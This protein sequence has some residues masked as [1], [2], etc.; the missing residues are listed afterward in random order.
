MLFFT[1]HKTLLDLGVTSMVPSH[2]RDMT[3]IILSLSQLWQYFKHNILFKRILTFLF[4]FQLMNFL[5][6]G[7]HFVFVIYLFVAGG[8][9]YLF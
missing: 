9:V 1:E 3:L 6:D 8:V 7:N 5:M 2:V 4:T